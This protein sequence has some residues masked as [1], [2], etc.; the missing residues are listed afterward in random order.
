MEN[1]DDDVVVTKKKMYSLLENSQLL[2]VICA[3]LV[4]LVT[5][6]IVFGLWRFRRSSRRGVLFMG[7][8]DSGKTLLFSQLLYD[9]QCSTL[10]SVKENIG[11]YNVN[12]KQLRVIDI[13]GHERVRPKFFEKYKSLTKGIV[14][15]I[16]SVTFQKEIRDVAEL[17]YTILTDPVMASICPEILILCNKQDMTM[18]KGSNVIKSQLEKELNMLRV[19]KSSQLSSTAGSANNNIYLGQIGKDFEFSQCTPINVTFSESSCTEPATLNGLR[20]WINGLA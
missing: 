11:D 5:L 4:G 10:T 18:A 9:K 12:N 8:C 14:F 16:D 7:L 1:I 15:V 13:P 2:G 6:I 17:L 20:K 3:V 19:T